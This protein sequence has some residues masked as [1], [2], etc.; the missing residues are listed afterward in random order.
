MQFEPKDVADNVEILEASMM[1]EEI[2]EIA[3]SILKE[4][5]E[6]GLRFQDIAILYR[7][8]SYAYLLESI[9]PQFDI[10]FNIDIKP[11]MT[12]HPI[13]EMIRSLIEVIQTNWNFEPIMRLLKLMY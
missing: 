13:M 2:N 10:P 3:R 1:R 4:T 5:R 8:D 7:D 9:L 6:E 11:S 12:H